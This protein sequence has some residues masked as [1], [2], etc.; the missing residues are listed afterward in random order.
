MSSMLIHMLTNF[1][2]FR[3]NNQLCEVALYY[4]L[5]FCLVL[6]QHWEKCS[7]MNLPNIYH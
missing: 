4:S 7:L 2:I 3:K 5:L 1:Y 6:A